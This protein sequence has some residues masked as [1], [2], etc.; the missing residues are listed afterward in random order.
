MQNLFKNVDGAI[1][2]IYSH[3]YNNNSTKDSSN[4]DQMLFRA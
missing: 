3:K 1:H 2:F 4:M